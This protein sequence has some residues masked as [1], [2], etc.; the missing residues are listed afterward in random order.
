MEELQDFIYESL[1]QSSEP[2]L[3]AIRLLRI[4]DGGTSTQVKCSLEIYNYNSCPGYWA[5]SYTWGP[6]TPS[7][8]ILVNGRR[9]RVRQNLFNFMKS[10]RSPSNGDF[11]LWIDQICINQENIHERNNQVRWMGQYYSRAICVLTWLGIGTELELA[12][13]ESIQQM[14]VVNAPPAKREEPITLELLRGYHSIITNPYFG[15]LW[16]VQEMARAQ[17]ILVML[18]TEGDGP[19]TVSWRHF[20]FALVQIMFEVT[21]VSTTAIA[22]QQEMMLRQGIRDFKI[23]L[24]LLEVKKH[25]EAIDIFELIEAFS[26]FKC[27]DP[28]DKLYALQDIGHLRQQLFTIDYGKD[29]YQVYFDFLTACLSSISSGHALGDQQFDILARL[30]QAMGLQVTF[31][32]LPP[33][34]RSESVTQGVQGNGGKDSATSLQIRF[35]DIEIFNESIDYVADEHVRIFGPRYDKKTGKHVSPFSEEVFQG[36]IPNVFK[37]PASVDLKEIKRMALQDINKRLNRDES[38]LEQAQEAE[39]T[40]TV[41][42][43]PDSTGYQTITMLSGDI[44]HWGL[45]FL[46]S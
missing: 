20:N 3:H 34:V 44:S 32:V 18:G 43:G 30:A 9:F 37:V 1:P 6:E 40:S 24:Q 15:R 28:R 2:D 8:I 4:H 46:G 12:A 45:P 42:N 16:I 38:E 17:D 11:Y 5:L 31:Q 35:E 41:T 22:A 27:F 7:H 25:Q 39:N 14:D 21:I 36:R 29:K 19:V 10:F 23:L 33:E 26:D 13:M